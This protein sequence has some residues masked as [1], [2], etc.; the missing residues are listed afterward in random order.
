MDAKKGFI[1]LVWETGWK[2]PVQAYSKREIHGKLCVHH[3]FAEW[4][5][6]EEA[7]EWL[8]YAHKC[9][10]IINNQIKIGI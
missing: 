2:K 1:E 7:I 4:D 3:F 6:F 9:P 8:S 10:I 5:S